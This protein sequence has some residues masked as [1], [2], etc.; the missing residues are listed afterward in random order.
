MATQGVPVRSR[1]AVASR[2]SP[3]RTPPAIDA[4]QTEFDR[5]RQLCAD[6]LIAHALEKVGRSAFANWSFVEPLHYLVDSLNREA[7]LSAFGR[8]AARFDIVRALA[9]LLRLDAA[10]AI[11]PGIV[12]RP[13]VRPLF[14]TGLP[15]SGTTFLH[16]LLARDSGNAVP[17]SWQLIYPYPLRNRFRFGDWRRTRVALQ[18]AAYRFVAP[19]VADLHPM[20]ADGPQECSDITAQVFHSLRFDS[21]YHV[22]YY[23]DWIGRHDHRDAYRFHKRFLRHLDRQEP[24]RRWILKSPDHVFALD[25]I[26]AVYPDALFVFLHRDPLPVLASQLNLTEALRRSFSKRIDLEEIGR[27]VSSAIADTADRLCANREESGVLH[28]SYRSVIAAP[29]DAVRR[30]YAHVGLALTPRALERMGQWLKRQ[31]PYCARNHRR[32]LPEFGLNPRE[33]LARFDRYVQEFALTCEQP[34]G[35]RAA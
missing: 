24:G 13:I 17:R 27:S 28:L 15:R 25:A 5:R 8:R 16:G 2:A 31:K 26:R 12:A 30:I 6:D 23:Q 9:N 3:A 34:S 7:Q 18:F 11:D 19:G 29:I 32:Q 21:M 1:I 35:S 20:A 22:P 33:V 14:I 4:G 10:E